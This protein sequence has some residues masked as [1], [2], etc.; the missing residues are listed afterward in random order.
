MCCVVCQNIDSEPPF[1]D[2]SSTPWASSPVLLN[3]ANVRVKM[4]EWK[5]KE[6]CIRPEVK[7]MRKKRGF[8]LVMW[9]DNDMKARKRYKQER[10]TGAAGKQRKAKGSEDEDGDEGEDE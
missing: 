6:V 1:A 3:S 2:L 10:K 5:W 9:G 8:P 4:G 7:A